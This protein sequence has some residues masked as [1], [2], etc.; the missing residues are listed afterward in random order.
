MNLPD[1]DIVQIPANQ[2]VVHEAHINANAPIARARLEVDRIAFQVAQILGIR[3]DEARFVRPLCRV[4]RGQ[5]LHCVLDLRACRGAPA[6]L[7]VRRPIPL[8]QESELA[9]RY[10]P[11]RHTSDEH[12]ADDQEHLQANRV[13]HEDLRCSPYPAQAPKRTGFVLGLSFV[14]ENTGWMVGSN[15]SVYNTTTGGM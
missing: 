10:L 11:R 4:V 7:R 15:L 1:F 2:T 13:V 9:G 12:Q 3:G 6:A 5:D 14:D 8:V